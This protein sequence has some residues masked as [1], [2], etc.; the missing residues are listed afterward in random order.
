MEHRDVR[1]VEKK[2]QQT[3]ESVIRPL[4]KN[5]NFYFLT[6]MD[7]QSNFWKRQEI[8]AIIHLIYLLIDFL[9][10]NIS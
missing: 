10:F 5:R 1:Y 7:S 4:D 8:V 3:T 6:F 2:E 9:H